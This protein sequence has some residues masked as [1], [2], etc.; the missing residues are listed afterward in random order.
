MSRR[1]MLGVDGAFGCAG[2]ADEMDGRVGKFKQRFKSN[3]EYKIVEQL[4]HR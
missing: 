1:I 4:F 3:K 2:K